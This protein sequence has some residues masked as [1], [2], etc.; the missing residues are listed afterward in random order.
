[1]KQDKTDALLEN[2][3]RMM[4]EFDDVTF[5]IMMTQISKF[6]EY[7]ENDD[8][9]TDSD[10]FRLT[11]TEHAYN[12]DEI[13]G[14]DWN[15]YGRGPYPKNMDYWD[16]IECYMDLVKCNALCGDFDIPTKDDFVKH[17]KKVYKKDGMLFKY[18]KELKK[19]LKEKKEFEDCDEED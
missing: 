2:A 13:T 8:L 6:Y 12:F 17:A 19:W 3:I 4:M 10:W 1:M 9:E 15:D 5:R 14:F 7:G 18:P 16:A 11:M